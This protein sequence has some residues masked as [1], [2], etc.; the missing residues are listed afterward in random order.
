MENNTSIGAVSPKIRY[1]HTPNMLQYAGFT[2]IHNLTIRNHAVG[3]NQIDKGQFDVD[4]KTFFAHGAAML[5]SRETIKQIG[6]MADIFFLYYEELDWGNRI[7]KS[8][9]EIHY[10]HN[11][12]IYHKESVSTGLFSPMQVYYL[13][14]SRLLYMRRN[15]KGINFLLSLLYLLFISIPKNYLTFLIKHKSKL[16]LA[17]HNAIAWHVKL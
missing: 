8:G 10:V 16:F 3:F 1:H 2:P 12:L 17:Y 5:V 14:R 15:I 11:S 4:S 6:M 9:K 7:R 13:N